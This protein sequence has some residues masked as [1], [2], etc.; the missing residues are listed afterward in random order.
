MLFKIIRQ[1]KRVESTRGGGAIL[2]REASLRRC[3]FSKDLK[4]GSEGGSPGE[5]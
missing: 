2:S 5:T 4:E 3:Q 1:E